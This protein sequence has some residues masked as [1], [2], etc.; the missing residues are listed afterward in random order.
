MGKEKGKMSIVF[1]D[2]A[3]IPPIFF[4]RIAEFFR[5]QFPLLKADVG[6]EA[7]VF[8]E[9]KLSLDGYLRPVFGWPNGYITGVM[10]L[11]I[12]NPKTQDLLILD[13]KSERN[14]HLDLAG[15]YREQLELYS[16][17]FHHGQAPVK[18]HR[19]VLFACYTGEILDLTGGW[20]EFDP[21]V[22]R[23]KMITLITEAIEHLKVI[24][25][26]ENH[27]C[28]YCFAQTQCPL[29]K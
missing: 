9:L 10:D 28:K 1:P 29:F 17:L 11:A 25:P 19:L 20:Q 6:S 13:Y 7:E 14:P 26:T 22:G 16:L 18:R 21:T 8:N 2:D 24:K 4:T 15:E 12:Y 5:T 27:L 3:V 23:G